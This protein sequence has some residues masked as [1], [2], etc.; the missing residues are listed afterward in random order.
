MIMRRSLLLVLLLA[1]PG[2]GAEEL[3]EATGLTAAAVRAIKTH[4][5]AV[6]DAQDE[7]LRKVIRADDA[8]VK[9]LDSELKKAVTA[10]RQEQAQTLRRKIDEVNNRDK[11]LR[12][13]VTEEAGGGPG[14]GGDGQEVVLNAARLHKLGAAKAGDVITVQYVKGTWSPKGT[15]PGSPDTTD[16]IDDR[17]RL[18]LYDKEGDGWIKLA[19]VP[20]GTVG[21]AWTFEVISDKPAVHIGINDKP[22]DAD[23][24]GEVI[25]RVSLRRR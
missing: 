1:G 25:V 18:A 16:R 19:V 12:P 7:Y 17:Y 13:F 6:T 22:G 10:D 4:I 14:G 23:N 11:L 20:G 15:D 3:P 21:K 2:G 24:V 9:M 8:L 5:K